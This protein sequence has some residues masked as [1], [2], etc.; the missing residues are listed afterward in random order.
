MVEIIRSR[1]L[2][3]VPVRKVGNT[4]IRSALDQLATGPGDHVSTWDIPMS[5]CIRFRARGCFKFTVV[6]D[7]VRR[8]L[9]A[10]GNRVLHYGETDTYLIDRLLLRALGLP[11]RPGIEEF[12]RHYR[13]YY[14]LNDRIRRH[15]RPQGVYLGRDLG[16]FDKIYRLEALDELAADLSELAGRQIEI[17]RLQTGGPK[18]DFAALDPKTQRLILRYTASDYQ[19]LHDHYSPP[20]SR[21]NHR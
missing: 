19:L 9:S 14:L 17:P 8:F 10:H 4:S 12:C 11:R 2:A 15:F 16:W 5:P 1:K 21:A 18:V 13:A 6:R 20:G 3:Y 7:P